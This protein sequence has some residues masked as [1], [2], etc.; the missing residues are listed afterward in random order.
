M[1]SLPDSLVRTNLFELFLDTKNT[2]LFPTMPSDQDTIYSQGFNFGSFVQEGV[3]PRT[4]QFTSSIDL[5][6]ALAKTRNCVP[7]KLSLRFSPL[8]PDNAGFRKG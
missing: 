6:E 1:S 7:F 2:A 3:D 4:G 5:Y 8:N